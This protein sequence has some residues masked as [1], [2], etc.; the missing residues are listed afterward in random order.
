MHQS[1]SASSPDAVLGSS[2]QRT[3]P[4][5]QV[6]LRPR[7]AEEQ[8]RPVRSL[9]LRV[10]VETGHPRSEPPRHGIV[11]VRESSVIES[12]TLIFPILVSKWE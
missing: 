9:L 11:E 6:R 4:R 1:F 2:R 3:V 8:R 12:A 10:E 7:T 5:P